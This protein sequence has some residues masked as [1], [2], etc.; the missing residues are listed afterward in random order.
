MTTY[1]LK[2]LKRS[3]DPRLRK[4]VN[5]ETQKIQ[6]SFTNVDTEKLSTTDFGTHFQSHSAVGFDSHIKQQVR[7]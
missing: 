4:A 2:Q 1:T 7:L 6:S 5:T 3:M